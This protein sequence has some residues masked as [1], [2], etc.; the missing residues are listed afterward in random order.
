[1]QDKAVTQLQAEELVGSPG[2]AHWNVTLFCGA[3]EGT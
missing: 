2:H 1:M 3:Q